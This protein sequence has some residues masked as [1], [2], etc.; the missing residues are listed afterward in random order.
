MDAPAASPP[1]ASPAPAAAPPAAA[2]PPAAPPPVAVAPSD[3]VN[4]VHPV[5]DGL[6]GGGVGLLLGLLTGLS[7]SPIVGAVVGAVGG[8]LGVFLGL[9]DSG[10]ASRMQAW[11]MVGFGLGASLGLVGGLVV[12]TGDRLSPTPAARLA[13]WEAAGIKGREARDLVRLEMGL[14]ARVEPAAPGSAGAHP[15][16]A[17]PTAGAPTPHHSV[18]FADGALPPEV[19]AEGDPSRQAD[20]EELPDNVAALSPRLA[21]LA[22]ALRSVAPEARAAVYAAAWGLVCKP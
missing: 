3:P 13:R 1:P 10:P 15:P 6:A 19:C 18:L 4:P 17:P 11:R 21:P 14:P 16:A 12:R 8:L 9:R 5:V 20:P 7:A 2:P 22:Q